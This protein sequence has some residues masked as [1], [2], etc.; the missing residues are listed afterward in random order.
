MCTLSLRRTRLR[1]MRCVC[2]QAYGSTQRFQRSHSQLHARAESGARSGGRGTRKLWWRC[3]GRRWRSGSPTAPS[4]CPGS[5]DVLPQQLSR[6]NLDVVFTADVALQVVTHRSPRVPCCRTGHCP[7]SSPARIPGASWPW[8]LAAKRR[9]R[10]WGGCIGGGRAVSTCQAGRVHCDTRCAHRA[11]RHSRS[12]SK[13]VRHCCWSAHQCTVPSV[14][15]GRV[16]VCIAA[17]VRVSGE[18]QVR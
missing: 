9:G 3:T 11:P 17:D 5:S 4:S 7:A 15:A 12:A 8:V 2:C 13:A 10:V 16:R 14:V 6:Q 18:H 1:C